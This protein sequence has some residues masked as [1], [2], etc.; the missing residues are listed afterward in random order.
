MAGSLSTVLA[1]QVNVSSNHL[2]GN[3][4]EVN[5]AF[6]PVNGVHMCF[7]CP[8]DRS[9]PP[10]IS[11]ARAPLGSRSGR[12]IARPGEHLGITMIS[13]IKLLTKPPINLAIH[14]SI[15]PSIHQSINPSIHQSIN[16]S[17]HQSISPSSDFGNRRPRQVIKSCF[18]PL[19]DFSF[20]MSCL[21]PSALDHST[22]L[23]FLSRN[24][25]SLRYLMHIIFD[26]IIVTK[27]YPPFWTT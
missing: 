25:C 11:P 23:V 3:T 7:R 8:L 20:V 22:T 18:V 10:P 13:S 19:L 6:T 9:P 12:S 24:T 1:L 17:I 16:P 27:L 14:Q 15:N 26:T 5:T 2:F 21:S 4:D